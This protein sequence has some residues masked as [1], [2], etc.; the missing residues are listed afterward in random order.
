VGLGHTGEDLDAL[1]ADGPWQL[2]RDGVE[3]QY[4]HRQAHEPV[5]AL[6][7]Y[8][9]GARV[10]AHR[11]TGVEFVQILHGSQRDAEGIYR[12][13]NFKVNLAGTAHE[14]LSDDGCVVLIVWAAPIEFLVD[15]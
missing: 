3:V 1:I 10:P 2:L 8:Q 9:P 13:G 12:A 14:V 15:A 6:L 4:L 5:A 7:R 11:H